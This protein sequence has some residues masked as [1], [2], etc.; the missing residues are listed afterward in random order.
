MELS[1]DFLGVA[2][3]SKRDI[4]LSICPDPNLILQIPESLFPEPTYSKEKILRVRNEHIGKSLGVSYKK[5]L[6][7]VRGFMQ[8]LYDDEGR[9]YLDVRNNVPQVGHSNPYIV[10][11]LSRQ[12]AVLNTNTRYL[13]EN[14]AR[15]FPSSKWVLEK[16]IQVSAE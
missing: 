11:A 1:S 4:W 9:Q 8:Y 2:P 16:V 10:D 15:F 6:H 7:I 13:H 3:P 14:L 12:A 5:P